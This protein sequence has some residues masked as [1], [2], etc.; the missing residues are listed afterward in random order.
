MRE[1]FKI[2][3]LVAVGLA[4]GHLIGTLTPPESLE[5]VGFIALCLGFFVLGMQV[6]NIRVQL[7]LRRHQPQ[8]ETGK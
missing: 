4:A 5:R 6:E 3:L 1:P 7:I 2:A 8:G